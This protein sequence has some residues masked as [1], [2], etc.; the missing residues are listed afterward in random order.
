[1][2]KYRKAIYALLV[3]AAFIAALVVLSWRI[4][5]EIANRTVNLSLDYNSLLDLCLEERLDEEDALLKMKEAGV[6]SIA[7][8][9]SSLDLLQDRGRLRWITGAEL[10]GTLSLTRP[11]K[12]LKNLSIDPSHIYVMSYSPDLGKFLTQN[13]QLILG[14]D[15]VREISIPTVGEDSPSIPALEIRGNPKEL[16]YMGLGFDPRKLDEI[17]KMGFHLVLRPENHD[18]MNAESIKNYMEKIDAI[19]GVQCIVFGGEN[20][21]LGYPRNLD[22][23]VSAFKSSGISFGDIEAPNVRAK[24]K[25]AT[26][27][28]QRILDQVV[29]VQ[30]ISP[31]YLAK[32]RP[33]NAIDMFRLGVRERNIRLLYLRPYPA[34]LN[35]KTV[36]QTNLKY[37]SNLRIEIQ[38]FGFNTGEASRFPIREVPMIVIVLISLGVAGIFLLLLDRFY[39]DSGYIAVA[40]IILAIILPVALISIHKLHWAQKIIGLALGVLFPVCAFAYHF[41]EMEFIQTEKKLL[42]VLGYA[43][44]MYLKI[45]LVTIL[46]GLMLAA[47]F[48]STSYMLSVDLVRGVKILLMLPPLLILLLYYMKG[49]GQRQS[50]KELLKAPLYLWQV[51]ILGIMGAAGMLF[52]ARSGNTSDFAASSSERQLRVALEHLM[53]V[54]PRLKDFVLGHPSLLIVWALSYLHRYA[55]MGI[56]VLFAGV[57]QADIIDTFAHVHTPLFISLL[58]VVNGLILGCIIG[59]LA[60]C[61]YWLIRRFIPEQTPLKVGMNTQM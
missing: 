38:K 36:L 25:G 43:L 22:A 30:S 44:S 53:W 1:L 49:T 54:R 55:G 20:E 23:T 45:S 37:I 11:L 19:P 15:S 61:L 58:R 39:Y 26:F 56:F 13:S 24:Q 12:S 51:A 2:V 7:F 42:K 28:S 32:M 60:I 50:L 40:V 59:V 21:V 17:R 16:P 47:L 10:A 31:Q 4:R 29:R 33:E 6:T 14:K 35:G 18:G 48:S 8:S 9:E 34:G 3:I 52:M 5:A 46:G 57:G 27:I 41:E